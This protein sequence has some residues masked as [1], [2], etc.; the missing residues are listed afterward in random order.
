MKGSAVDGVAGA[1][2]TPGLPQATEK[3][4]VVATRQRAPRSV[5][6]L[7]RAAEAGGRCMD[8]LSLVQGENWQLPSP[9]VSIEVVGVWRDASHRATRPPVPLLRVAWQASQRA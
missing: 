8:R 1:V 5:L 2:D 6:N 9:G 7:I 3:S 4:N